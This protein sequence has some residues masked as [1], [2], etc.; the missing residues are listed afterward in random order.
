MRLKINKYFHLTT[1]HRAGWV[2]ISS[3]TTSHRAGWASHS[4]DLEIEIASSHVHWFGVR[5]V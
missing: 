5:L 2:N 3:F 4:L 1:S